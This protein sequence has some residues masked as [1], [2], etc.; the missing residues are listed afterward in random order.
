VCLRRTRQAAGRRRRRRSG[1]LGATARRATTTSDGAAKA[2]AS[3][4][5]RQSVRQAAVSPIRLACKQRRGHGCETNDERRATNEPRRTRASE[6]SR[7]RERASWRAEPH[8]HACQPGDER[9]RSTS[10]SRTWATYTAGGGGDDPHTHTRTQDAHTR[11][12]DAT[13]TTKERRSEGGREPRQRKAAEGVYEV[14]PTLALLYSA[15][16][17][18]HLAP[19]AARANREA[20]SWP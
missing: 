3:R 20:V 7:E 17:P 8:T 19:P 15:R 5:R 2:H 4:R 18:D 6:C 1:E 9:W 12:R 13:T 14:A 16:V 11:H 10:A